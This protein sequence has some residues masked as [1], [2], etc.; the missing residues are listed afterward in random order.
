MSI[1]AIDNYYLNCFLGRNEVSKA[2]ENTLSSQNNIFFDVNMKLL[3]KINKSL[4]D[5]II[6]KLVKDPYR[7]SGKKV[8]LS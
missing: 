4:I 7:A 5:K 3:S 2:L 1:S 8:E 6:L